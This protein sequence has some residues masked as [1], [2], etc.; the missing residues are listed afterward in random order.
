MIQEMRRPHEL[1]FYWKVQ[2]RLLNPGFVKHG[3][4]SRQNHRLKVA[5][6]D[7]EKQRESER[8]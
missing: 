2:P 7:S 3:P 1:T 6:L 5:A 8:K 4:C